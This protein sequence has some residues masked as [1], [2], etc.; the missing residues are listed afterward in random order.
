MD[1]LGYLNRF[2]YPVLFETEPA[3]RAPTIAQWIRESKMGYKV[4]DRGKYLASIDA[5]LAEPGILAKTICPDCDAE[6]VRQY[7]AEVRAELSKG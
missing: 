1:A 7:L 6:K 5:F 2:L 4:E 3:V